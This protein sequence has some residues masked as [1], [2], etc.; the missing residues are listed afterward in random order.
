[1]EYKGIWIVFL[2]LWFLLGVAVAVFPSRS[3]DG[4]AG[5]RFLASVQ[6]SRKAVW[7]PHTMRQPEYQ[8][9]PTPTA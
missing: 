3:G 2:S 4:G 6:F 8:F 1:M 9:L 5:T 7:Q